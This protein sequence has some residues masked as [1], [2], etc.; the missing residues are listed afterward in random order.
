MK[1]RNIPVILL[2][3][4]LSVSC[5]VTGKRQLTIIETTDIHGVVLP[6]DYVEKKELKASL[7]SVYTYIK[8]IRSENKSLVLLDDGDN[9]QG[10]PAVYYYNF[11]DTT[12]PHLLSEAFNYMQY[13]AVTAGNHDVETGHSVYDRIRKEYK[14]PMLAANAVDLNTGK[15][16]FKPYTIIKRNGIKIAVLGLVTQTINNTLPSELY[17]GIE[18]RDLLETAQEWMPVI[19]NENPDLIVG[20]FHTGF[21][22]PGSVSGN[23]EYDDEKGAESIAVKVPGFDI[24]FTGHD[25]KLANEKIVNTEGDTVLVMNAG[26]RAMNIARADITIERDRKSK[27]LKKT[28]TG[29]LV[30]VSDYESNKEFIAKFSA[31]HNTVL[32]YV[33]EVIGQSGETISSRESYFGSSAFVDMIHK[34]QLELTNADISFAAPL[35]FDVSIEKG[36]VTVG[37]MFKLYRFENMLY[38]VTMTGT[39]ILNYLEFSYDGWYNTM[40]SAD[41]PLL[42]FRTDKSGKVLITDGKAWLRNPA[43]NF[44]SAAGIDYSVDVSKP[45]GEKI[46]IAGMTNGDPFIPEKKYTVAVNSYRAN[47]G[48]GHF[49]EGAGIKKDEL[50][51]RK[52]RSTDRDLRFY[53]I[54]SIRKMGNI[55]PAPNGNWKLVPENLTGKAVKKE[56]ELLFGND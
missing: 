44:D 30:K 39:E 43:Y 48:G 19:K 56:Y 2:A 31:Y 27:G 23:R 37:D 52:I 41:D 12:S 26:S 53:M 5:S 22:S 24:I 54:E 3:V 34:L 9:L 10:Q 13:D 49:R 38:T 42:K 50:L 4:L 6:Y 55:D 35:S 51:S 28:I 46:K 21:N 33:N 29:N 11:T 16:Y 25:H 36:P 18:F 1:L 17:E 7:A 20:L 8:G 14:F 47:G 40:K 15:P 45:E 32:D